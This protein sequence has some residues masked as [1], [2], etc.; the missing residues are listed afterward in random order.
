MFG[1]AFIDSQKRRRKEVAEIQSLG[2]ETFA[3]KKGMDFLVLIWR[4]W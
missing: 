2:L 3:Q 4:W 1:D